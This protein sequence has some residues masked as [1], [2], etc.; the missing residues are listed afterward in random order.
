MDQV[1]ART[2]LVG[3]DGQ[4]WERLVSSRSSVVDPQNEEP[5]SLL[6]SGDEIIGGRLGDLLRQIALGNAAG[7]KKIAYFEPLLNHPIDLVLSDCLTG[8]TEIDG[9]DIRGTWVEASRADDGSVV[10]RAFYDSKGTL[11]LEEYPDIH[12]V[13]RRIPGPLALSME[14][15]ELL[16]GLQSEAYISDPNTATRAKFRL[17]S[18][19]DRLDSLSLLSEPLNHSLKRT[20]PDEIILEVKAE[21][22]DG[23]GKFKTQ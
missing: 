6:L 9:Q 15:S 1:T 12:Q 2:F 23:S 8:A 10:I 4:G 18:T 21:A 14:T 3:F 16:V 17:T 11:W 13:R 5:E 22:P 19:P 7:K 20:A